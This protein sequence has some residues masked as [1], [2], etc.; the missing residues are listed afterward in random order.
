MDIDSGSIFD[1]YLDVIDDESD[2]VNLEDELR[3]I[4]S[5]LDMM[6]HCHFIFVRRKRCL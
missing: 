5:M 6:R 4:L 1:R 2:G 3:T